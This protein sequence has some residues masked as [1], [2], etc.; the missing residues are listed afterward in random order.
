MFYR[1][2]GKTMSYNGHL[3]DYQKYVLQRY[4][5]GNGSRKISL[6]STAVIN[7]DTS[8]SLISNASCSVALTEAKL[9]SGG[10]PHS[11]TKFSKAMPSSDPKGSLNAT[12]SEA[13]FSTLNLRER[14]IQRLIL[15]GKKSTAT[16]I[17]DESLELLKTRIEQHNAITDS[18]GKSENLYSLATLT[19]DEIFVI[20]LR[21]A[22]P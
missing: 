12:R 4:A 10:N 11:E 2:L 20:A 22:Q 7:T 9:S 15:D 21:K 3:L 13:D 16:K 8:G 19:K 17:F 18:R 1:T 6:F 14:F 5:F